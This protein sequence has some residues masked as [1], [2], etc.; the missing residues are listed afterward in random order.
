LAVILISAILFRKQEPLGGFCFRRESKLQ[1]RQSEVKDKYVYTLSDWPFVLFEVL[2]SALGEEFDR[3]SI[4]LKFFIK[5]INTDESTIEYYSSVAHE[6]VTALL[7]HK[8][9]ITKN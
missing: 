5:V 1:R 7:L 3:T 2:Y 8:Y 4:K 9:G 6:D